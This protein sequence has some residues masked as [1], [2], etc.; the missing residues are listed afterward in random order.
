[1]KNILLLTVVMMLAACAGGA[2]KPDA[3]VAQAQKQPRLGT[4][5]VLSRFSALPAQTLAKG[6]CGLF[7]WLKREDAPLV[8]FQR[9]GSLAAEMIVD[10]SLRALT[11]D[12][13]EGPIGMSFFER[14]NFVGDDMRV[15]LRIQVEADRSLQQ[16]LKVP[17]G[18]ISIDTH[19][20]WSAALPV[21][22][23]IG[24]K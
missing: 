6:E 1:M 16:G 15:N 8:F 7:L 5:E 20:G 11:R 24:C 19:E 17:S 21:A 4:D 3:R 14:Q 22:G 10:G 9:S 18:M 13:A 12:A 2:E 23:A